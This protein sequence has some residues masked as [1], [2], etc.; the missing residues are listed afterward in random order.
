[1]GEPIRLYKDGDTLTVYGP[2]HL[3][4]ALAEGWQR[5][6]PTHVTDDYG[7]DATPAQDVTAMPDVDLKF[8]TVPRFVPA[9]TTKTKPRK[10]ER[11]AGVL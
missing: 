6:A 2:Q 4:A 1:M 3:A 10:T 11:G 5:M 7:N 9:K 8:M